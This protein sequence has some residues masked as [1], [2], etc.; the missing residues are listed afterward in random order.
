MRKV[1]PA[2][3][4]VVALTFAITVV[5]LVVACGS[6]KTE[7]IPTVRVEMGE[8][9]F[10]PDVI[11][12]KEGE[13]VTIELVNKGKVAHEFMVGREVEMHEG[14]PE[15][16]EHDFF[17]GIEITFLGQKA[18]LER[19]EGHGTEVIVEADGNATLTFTVPTGTKG[20]WEFACFIPGHYEA[21]QKGTFIVE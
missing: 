8:F 15:G 14:A 16:Y 11:K 9:Y 6:G 2:I 17:V 1:R 20:K 10:K 12:A 4:L 3:F 21:G 19:E 7:P 18:E 13:R 5:A